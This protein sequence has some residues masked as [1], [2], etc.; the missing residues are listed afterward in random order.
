MLITCQKKTFGHVSHSESCRIN[1]TLLLI[2]QSRVINDKSKV[3]DQLFKINLLILKNKGSIISCFA[4][5]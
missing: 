5:E 2:D 1:Q 3:I 4:S